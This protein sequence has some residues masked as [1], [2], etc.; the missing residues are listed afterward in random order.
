MTIQI[1]R[2]SEQILPA[3]PNPPTPPT[4]TTDTVYSGTLKSHDTFLYGKFETSVKMQ[5]VDGTAMNFQMFYEGANSG[6]TNKNAL[7][8]YLEPS[9]YGVSNETPFWTRYQYWDGAQV[10][11]EVE[12]ETWPSTDWSQFQTLAME[13]TPTYIKY[14][15]NGS[16]IRTATEGV[17]DLKLAQHIYL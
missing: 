5:N 7:G 15:L 2:T 8:M 16:L 10:Q 14:Y 1:S 17:S 6:S 4:P 11:S 12:Y 9:R 13:W 3:D